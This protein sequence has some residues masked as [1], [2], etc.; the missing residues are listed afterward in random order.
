L[1]SL[2]DVHGFLSS[3][4][5]SIGLGENAADF[6][7]KL[8]I[9]DAAGLPAVPQDHAAAPAEITL[10]RHPAVS[11]WRIRRAGLEAPRWGRSAVA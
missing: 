4:R 10:T 6:D 2:L 3:T 7:E 8:I 9:G 1:P 11:T 5:T